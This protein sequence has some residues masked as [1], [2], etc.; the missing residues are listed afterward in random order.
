MTRL[1]WVSK[2]IVIQGSEVV[3]LHLPFPQTREV[4]VLG[5]I[6]IRLPR[7]SSIVLGGPGPALLQPVAVTVQVRKRAAA[8]H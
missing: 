6:N 2:V 7:R 1:Q 4:Q 5:E 8:Y 3:V